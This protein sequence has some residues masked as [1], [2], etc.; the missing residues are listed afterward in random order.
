M[1]KTSDNKTQ[2]RILSAFSQNLTNTSQHPLIRALHLQSPWDQQQVLTLLKQNPQI[3]FAEPNY[4]VHLV[5][6]S[7]P[8]D[9]AFDDQWSL[10][11]HGQEDS[12]RNKGVNGA[13][14]HVMPLWQQG[15]TGSKNVLVAMVDTGL[16]WQHPDLMGNLYENPG[17]AGAKSNNGIDDDNN[18]YIDDVHGWNT[19]TNSPR[20][21]DDAGHGSHVAGII[22]AV[23]NNNIGVT[24]INWNASLLPVKALGMTGGGTTESVVNALVYA[25]K[26]KA[27]IINNSWAMAERS[28]ILEHI[29]QETEKQGILMIAASGNS[30]LNL[31]GC[32][33]YPASFK[34]S[35]V[36]T[37]SATDNSDTNWYMSDIGPKTV[38]VA[39]PGANIY[40]TFQK[41]GYRSLTGTSMAAPHVSGIAALLK[42]AHPEWDYKELRKRIVNSCVPSVNLRHKVICQGRVDA[43]NALQ[44]IQ[45]ANPFKQDKD[46]IS[47]PYVVESPH[48]YENRMNVYYEIKHPGAKFIRAHIQNLALEYNHD[49]IFVED[50]NG[51]RIEELVYALQD[52]NTDYVEGDTLR[53]HLKTDTSTTFYG[54]KVD[55]IGYIQ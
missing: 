1:F 4:E 17:E 7:I 46:F 33:L 45:P 27:Q 50:A 15:I 18:G 9:Y 10:V 22:G 23:G 13:D 14:I 44:G 48:P 31:D 28:D 29:I 37:V 3:Q 39:A 11:N 51:N 54:F 42:S 8:N 40:S 52:Y 16:D 2:E 53:I 47:E 34:Y 36:I 32:A 25:I 6:S 12:D 38:D 21:Q 24:G 55:S 20:S 19:L 41:Q 26:M 5:S 35:N 30:F 49:Q 43:W